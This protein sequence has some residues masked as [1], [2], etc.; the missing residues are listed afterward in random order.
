MCS[1]TFFDLSSPF[2]FRAHTHTQALNAYVDSALA[3]PL[4]VSCT[5]EPAMVRWGWANARGDQAAVEA[6]VAE[7]A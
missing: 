1:S 7:L 6:A 2:L 3:T 4:L 5:P